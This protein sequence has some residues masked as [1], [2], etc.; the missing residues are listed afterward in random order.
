M[1]REKS[2]ALMNDIVARLVISDNA[3]VQGCCEVIERAAAE[4]V[5]AEARRT[6]G[7]RRQPPAE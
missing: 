7:R 1:T 5:A 3:D 2:M 6:D 4:E